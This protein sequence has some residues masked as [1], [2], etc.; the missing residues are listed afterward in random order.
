MIGTFQETTKSG[1]A[2]LHLGMLSG[3]DVSSLSWER[4]MIMIGVRCDSCVRFWL[5]LAEVGVAGWGLFLYLRRE[6]P[7]FL[8][9]CP[10][11]PGLGVTRLHSQ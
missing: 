5:V 2:D 3:V 4:L 8:V 10:E 6:I 7:A 1:Q 9:E 11:N